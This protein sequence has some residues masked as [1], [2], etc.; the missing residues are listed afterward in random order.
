MLPEVRPVLKRQLLAFADI[1]PRHD[2]GV[3]V[4]LVPGAKATGLEGS[5]L[6]PRGA[7]AAAV[8]GR[9]R[10]AL[11]AAAAAERGR[12]WTVKQLAE[13]PEPRGSFRYAARQRGVTDASMA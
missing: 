6:G 4:R 10:G 9:I 3:A 13:T 11:E 12:T 7:A 5:G 8:S 2:Y 1:A